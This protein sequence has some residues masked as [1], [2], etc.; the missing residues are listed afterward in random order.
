MTFITIRLVETS[1]LYFRAS[2]VEIY[3]MKVGPQESAHLVDVD[4]T[5][6]IT[7]ALTVAYHVLKVVFFHAGSI[8]VAFSRID[9][10]CK[11]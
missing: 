9:I 7:P 10:R 3:E 8:N 1:G 11:R 6:Y 5:I 4:L 2:E